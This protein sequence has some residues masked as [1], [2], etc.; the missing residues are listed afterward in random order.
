MRRSSVTVHLPH[1]VPEVDVPRHLS[2]PLTLMTK[3]GA[4]GVTTLELQAAGCLYPSKSV[5]KLKE[6]GAL[7]RTEKCKAIDVHGTSRRS[8][9][10]YTYQGWVMEKEM[11]DKDG[12]NIKDRL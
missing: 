5:S 10:R 1:L 7:I 12:N 3:A 6:R 8:I 2:V 9:A 11:A 4:Q